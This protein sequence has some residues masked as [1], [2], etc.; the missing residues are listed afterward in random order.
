MRY[1][2]RFTAMNFDPKRSNAKPLPPPNPHGFNKDDLHFWVWQGQRLIDLGR[3]VKR[4]MK[5]TPPYLKR[6]KVE[7]S[8]TRANNLIELAA[9]CLRAAG[10][11]IMGDAVPTEPQFTA[12]VQMGVDELKSVLAMKPGYIPQ[13]DEECRL[14]DLSALTEEHL[15]EHLS[16]EYQ[17]QLKSV[18]DTLKRPEAHSLAWLNLSEER[19]REI[20]N[21]ENAAHELKKILI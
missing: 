19:M 18:A 15:K 13:T 9:D 6:K 12:I 3:A 4:D 21:A 10:N 11:L 20:R 14:F 7:D 16:F 2:I 17:N 1:P 8:T 5:V